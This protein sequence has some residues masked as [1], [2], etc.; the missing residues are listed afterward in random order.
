[1]SGQTITLSNALTINTNLTIDASALTNGIQI[2]G[3]NSVTIFNVASG[4][5]NVLNSLTLTNGYNVEFG[6]GVGN[7]GTLTMN[8]CTLSG[9]SAQSGGGIFNNS[10]TLTLNQCTLSGNSST[11]NLSGGGGGVYNVSG[12]LTMN[13][14]TLSENSAGYGGGGINNDEGTVTVS[15]CTLSGNNATVNTYGGGGG[16]YNNGILTLNQCTLSGNDANAGSG[17][18]IYNVSGTLSVNQCTLS[19]NAALF[20]NG[21]GGIANGGTLKVNQCTLS[22]NN[23]DGLYGSGGGGGGILNNGVLMITNTIVAGNS[24]GFPGADIWNDVTLTYGGANLVQS[25]Y[26]YYSGATITGPVPINAAPNLAA[27]GNYGGPTQTMPLLPG[28][29]AIGAGSVAA[30]TFATDQRGYPRTQNGLIDIGAVE[31][32]TIRFT[33]S[34]TDGFEPLTVQFNSPNVDSDGSAIINWNWSF[35]DGSTSTNQNPSHSYITVSSFSPSLIVTNSLDLT[36]AASGPSITASPLSVITGI[37]LSDTNLVLNGS[38][39]I[40]GLTYYVLTTTNL[41]LP[42]SQWT[43]LATNLWSNN[44]NFNFTLNNAV[45]PNAPQQFYILEVQ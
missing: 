28:S 34:P 44:G 27:L 6:G 40:S 25:V 15:G 41:A 26:N 37:S 32:P 18:G 13:E 29:P 20:F 17:G 1:M 45:N 8:Q 35:G 43:P 5:T 30:N 11:A 9:N 4:T 23:A 22:G 3:N 16:I 2:N 42:L 24:G 38:N 36:L 39:G 19:G 12:E 21:G 7:S 14:C 10:G 33:A 31:L